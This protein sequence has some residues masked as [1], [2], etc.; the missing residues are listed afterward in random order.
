MPEWTDTDGTVFALSPNPTWT[1]SLGKR[2]CIIDIDTRPLDGEHQVLN[3]GTYSWQDTKVTSA[4]MMGH[5]LYAQIHGYDYKFVRTHNFED[6]SSFWTKISALSD[7]LQDYEFVVSIDADAQFNHPEIPFEWLLNRWN[8]TQQ[9]ALTMTIDPD[10]EINRD[11]RGRPY[12]NGGFVVAHNIPRTHEMLQAWAACPD[13]PTEFYAGCAKWKE[14]WPA[15]QAAFGDYVRYM[16]DQPDDLNEVPCDEA[17]GFPDSQTACTGRFVRH[18]WT[19]KERTKNVIAN[20][21]MQ[22]LFGQLHD[23]FLAS[24]SII[25]R[26]SNEFMR[27]GNK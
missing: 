10:L 18:M 9:T 2:L 5:Y 27:A 22:A 23:Q 8:V 6:R 14:P 4:G 17:N 12:N 13:E 16:Y 25:E 15:E 11:P 7:T 20:G 24:D 26:E 1:K 21:V 19:A 3:N